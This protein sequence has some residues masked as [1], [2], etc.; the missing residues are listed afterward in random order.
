MISKKRSKELLDWIEAQ[1]FHQIFVMT[2]MGVVG[3]LMDPWDVPA[4]RAIEMMQPIWDATNDKV[5]EV[6]TSTMV[7]QKVH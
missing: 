5:Y 2:Y 4:K 1:W 7:Y 6:T 3:Q